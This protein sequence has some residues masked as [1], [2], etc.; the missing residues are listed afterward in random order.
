MSRGSMGRK[1]ARG[2]QLGYP[3]IPLPRRAL[4]ALGEGELSCY[5]CLVL[6]FLYD[7]GARGR[8]QA[9]ATLGQISEGIGWQKRL[10]T[11]SKLIRRL[12]AKRWLDYQSRPGQNGHR[13]VF[14]L[15]PEP[16]RVAAASEERPS[17]KSGEDPSRRAPDREG[18]SRAAEYQRSIGSEPPRERTAAQVPRDRLRHPSPKLAGMQHLDTKRGSITAGAVRAAQSGEREDVLSEERIEEEPLGSLMKEVIGKRPSVSGEVCSDCERGS[19]KLRSY[20]TLLLCP[21][22]FNSRARVAQKTGNRR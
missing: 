6:I 9:T 7:R 17:Q 13:Y 10:D 16:R 4:Q 5:E 22:C 11:L 19:A 1:D 20:N 14:E 15:L 21:D 3:L 8:R 12:K 18:L 2:T